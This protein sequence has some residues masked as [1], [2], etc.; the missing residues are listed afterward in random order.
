MAWPGQID[1]KV[2]NKRTGDKIAVFSEATGFYDSGSALVAKTK[3]ALA[4][5]SG[6][7][8]PHAFASVIHK[9]GWGIGTPNYVETMEKVI[10]SYAKRMDCPK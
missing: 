4:A 6:A 5:V 3:T 7:M 1:A 2:Y 8:D 9:F 10:E